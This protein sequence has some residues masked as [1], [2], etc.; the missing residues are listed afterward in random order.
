MKFVLLYGPMAVGKLT[1]ARALK[2]VCGE[3]NYPIKI[4]HN[5][6]T[7][8]LIDEFIPTFTKE[9][10]HLN[11]VFRLE[12]YEACAKI[13]QN[14][15]STLVYAKTSDDDF[16]HDIIGAIGK[17]GGSI[18][19]IHLTADLEV[20]YSRLGNEDRKQYSKLTSQEGYESTMS[21]YDI[22]SP[23][24]FVDNFSFDTAVNSPDFIAKRIFEII[25]G[26]SSNM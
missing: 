15:I 12:M 24:P 10:F 6:H 22:F 14:L 8:D 18:L 19:F 7:V 3:N 9:W 11:S 21:K 20:L 26:Y 16:I 4:F 17:H 1:V 23:I 5:H 2:K 13:G 25:T